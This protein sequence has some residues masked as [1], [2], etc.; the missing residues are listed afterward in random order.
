[1]FVDHR[2]R[3]PPVR[4]AAATAVMAAV[5]AALP[6]LAPDPVGAARSLTAVQQLA[7][8]AGADTVVLR[9]A[10][11]LAWAVWAWGAVGLLLT[12][13]S[14]LPGV[15]GTLARGL[16]HVVLPAGARRAASLALGIGIGLN[17]TVVAGT[18]LAG[19]ALAAVPVTAPAAA[20][21]G[22]PEWPTAVPAAPTATAAPAAPD[23]PASNP[24]QEHVVVRGDCLWRI[25]EAALPSGAGRPTDAEVAGAVRAWW[26]A[27]AAVIGPDPDLVLPGQVLHAPAS[28]VPTPGANR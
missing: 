10:G 26:S 19:P 2:R 3:T 28:A 18:V 1:M 27:N 14:A 22:A 8:T 21:L 20:D 6:L 9:V 7:D 13:G 5:G 4:I 23:W 16:L 12:A 17:G 11:L 25:A 15:A 24:G